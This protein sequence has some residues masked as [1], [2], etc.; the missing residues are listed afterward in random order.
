MMPM[1]VA[2]YEKNDGTV[3]ISRMR[4]KMMKNLTGGVIRAEMKKSATDLEN[5][6]QR[7]IE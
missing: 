5:A 4:L 1:R 6:V 7:V 3:Y 2:V